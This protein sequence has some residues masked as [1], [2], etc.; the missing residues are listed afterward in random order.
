MVTIK[1]KNEIEKMRQACRLA[2]LTQKEIEKKIKPGIST[3]ELDRIAEIFIRENGGIP[4][5]K[6]IS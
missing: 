3:L 4:A 6:R 5:E 2:G 1:S